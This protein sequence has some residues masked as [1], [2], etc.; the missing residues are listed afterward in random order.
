MMK[1]YD[2]EYFLNAILYNLWVADKKFGDFMGKIVNILLYPIPKYLFTETYKKKCYERL[3]K[4]QKNIDKFF[5]DEKNGFH[6]GRANYLFGYIYSCYLG[7]LSFI[8]L[9]VVFK[10]IEGTSPLVK[11]FI[12]FIPIGIFYIPAYLAVFTKDRYLKY[13]KQ[14][15]QNDEQWHK[16]WKRVTIVFCIGAIITTFLGMGALWGILL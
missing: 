11:L 12:I 3:S 5:Y 10:Y 9:G 7:F 8:L 1:I 13:F 16:K 14:F 2:F 6:I 4:E 15:E